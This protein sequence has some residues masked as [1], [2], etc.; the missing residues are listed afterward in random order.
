MTDQERGKE[1]EFY[2][3]LMVRCG[4]SIEANLST[5]DREGAEMWYR[6]ARCLVALMEEQERLKKELEDLR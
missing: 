5:R 1:I 4:S 2:C 6:T 3:D